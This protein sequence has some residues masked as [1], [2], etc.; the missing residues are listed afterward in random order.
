MARVFVAVGSNIDPERN[1]RAAVR[2]LARRTRVV[3]ISTIYATAPLRRHEQATFYNGVVEIETGI[4]PRELRSEV[5]R[6]IE[7][8]LGRVRTGDRWAARTI[9]LD[10]AVY[11]DLVISDSDLQIPDPDIP[12]RAFLAV[13]LAELAPDLVLPGSGER[14]SEIAAAFDDHDMDPLPEYT[15]SLQEEIRT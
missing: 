7:A 1:V 6:C 9:D 15:Q 8:Q 13:P 10:I 2:A 5:L 11:N 14:L 3:A 4:P 12:R